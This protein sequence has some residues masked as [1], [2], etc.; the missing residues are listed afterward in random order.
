[1]AQCKSGSDRYLDYKCYDY[2][3]PKFDTISLS[4][5]R[6]GYLR[7]AVAKLEKNH[8]IY[9]TPYEEIFKEITS[10]VTDGGVFYDTTYRIPCSYI[11]YL[12]NKKLRSNGMHKNGSVYNIFEKFVAEVYKSERRRYDHGRVCDIHIKPLDDNIYDRMTILYELYNL[13]NDLKRT[14]PYKINDECETFGRMIGKYNDAIEKYQ[15]EDVELLNKILFFKDLTKNLTWPDADK[16][17]YQMY[18]FEEPKLYLRKQQEAKEKKLQEER[19]E[20]EQKERVQREQEKREQELHEREQEQR[21]REQE[22]EEQL[23][24]VL[25]PN[26]DVSGTRSALRTPKND[27][28]ALTLDIREEGLSAN[29][30][31]SRGQQHLKGN[32]F[33]YSRTPLLDTLGGQKEELEQLEVKSHELENYHV[34]QTDTPGVFGSLQN[35]ISSFI[36]EVEPA[37]VL[38]VS[39][40]MGVLFLLFKYT[41]I[42]AFFRGGRGRVHRIPRSFNGP[43][44]GGFPGYEEYDVG[45]I[46]YGPMNPLAE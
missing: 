1:M 25:P 20:R 26:G 19:E 29:P 44:P 31:P 40:G 27:V 34:S 30:I 33:T 2:L 32:K 38:G 12:L 7:D 6:T 10:R 42:G 45:H 17:Y 36:R 37:P 4:D 46:G 22:P 43:F 13:Y 18:R 15:L 3:K 35:S 8:L 28:S 23:E 41:P 11:N 16:C 14:H 39:G 9:T 21:E 5:T 24:S